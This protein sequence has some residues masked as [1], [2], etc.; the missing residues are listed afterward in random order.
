MKMP[1]YEEL[2]EFLKNHSDDW[3]VD[4]VAGRPYLDKAE[5]VKSALRH[6]GGPEFKEWT[7]PPKPQQIQENLRTI[8]SP[9]KP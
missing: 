6:F 7:E 3:T 9:E 5:L 8:L 1:S 2:L 4:V